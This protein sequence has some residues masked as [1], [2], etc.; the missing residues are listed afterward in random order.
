MHHNAK[1]Y[2]WYPKL[3]MQTR[4]QTHAISFLAFI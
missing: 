4:L 3:S 2:L 1:A